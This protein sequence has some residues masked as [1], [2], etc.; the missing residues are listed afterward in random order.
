MAIDKYIAVTLPFKHSQLCSTTRIKKAFF[1]LAIFAMA[2][3][4]PPKYA[5]FTIFVDSYGGRKKNGNWRKVARINQ[6]HKGILFLAIEMV[7]DAGPFIVIVVYTT[8]KLIGILRQQMKQAQ[9]SMTNQQTTHRS[10]R[11]RNLTIVMFAIILSNLIDILVHVVFRIMF[12]F[13]EGSTAGS[14]T[15][16]VYICAETVDGLQ[17]PL[18]HLIH[19]IIY[20]IFHE[21]FRRKARDLLLCRKG[22][23]QW[24]PS[25]SIGSIS[26]GSRSEN[27]QL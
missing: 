3:V 18:I 11:D 2:W 10:E 1:I 13:L 26:R 17:K 6:S 8:A 19:P 7:A 14:L 27:T 23:L 25:S 5:I 16:S 15:Y 24:T 12:V 22:N 21:Q 4:L 9:S 20:L